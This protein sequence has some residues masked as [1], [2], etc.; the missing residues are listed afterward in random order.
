MIK[1]FQYHKFRELFLI[2]QNVEVKIDLEI[3]GVSL[4]VYNLWVRNFKQQKKV[5]VSQRLPFQNY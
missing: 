4:D 1:L 2:E 5:G 3:L